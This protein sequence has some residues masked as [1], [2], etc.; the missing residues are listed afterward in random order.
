M[1][2]SSP[3]MVFKTSLAVDILRIIKTRYLLVFLKQ[4]WHKIF[5]APLSQACSRNGIK[6]LN[7][8]PKQVNLSFI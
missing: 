1:T 5:F 7:E 6:L 4:P 2:I 3:I 8:F